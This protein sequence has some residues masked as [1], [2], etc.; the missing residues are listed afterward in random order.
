[1]GLRV[2][3]VGGPNA[4]SDPLLVALVPPVVVVTLTLTTAALC[5]GAT[6]V[7]LVAVTNVTDV[8]A[9]VPNLTE[10]PDKKLVPL[11][12]TVLLPAVDPAFGLRLA[13]VGGGLNEYWS[14]VTI[15]VVPPGV[16]TVTL[17]VPTAC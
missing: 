16:V 8:A 17:T 2:L 10:A 4:Y 6:A 12:V 13:T 9:T 3:I 5:A 1:F 15:G 7:S 11:I 14:A